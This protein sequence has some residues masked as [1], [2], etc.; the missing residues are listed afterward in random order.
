MAFIGKWYKS[1]PRRYV[2]IGGRL[3]TKEEAKRAEGVEWEVATG[4]WLSDT[5]ILA[6]E[7][8][9]RVWAEKQEQMRRRAP[10]SGK[11]NWQDGTYYG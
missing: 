3:F 2:E 10:K 4:K 5:K 7:I 8:A 11:V 6:G 9:Q 1:A